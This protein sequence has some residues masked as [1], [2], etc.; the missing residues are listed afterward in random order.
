MP[1]SPTFLTLAQ[2]LHFHEYQIRRFGGEPGIRDAGLLESAIAQARVSYGGEYLHHDLYEMAAVYAW[3]ICRNHPFIDG[4]KRT[5][6]VTALVFLE[7]NGVSL[8]DPDEKLPGAIE[9]IAEGRLGKSEFAEL[10]RQ[11]PHA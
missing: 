8:L 7:V 6:L 4:N 5:G 1:K 3:H 9:K 11:L 2:V 10:L